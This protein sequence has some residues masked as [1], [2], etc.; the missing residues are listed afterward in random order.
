[1]VSDTERPLKQEH[2]ELPKLTMK[3]RRLIK[4]SILH[5]VLVSLSA[6]FM[7]PFFWMLTTALKTPAELLRGT[8]VLLP[9]TPQ[10][11]NF[12][13]AVTQV[14]FILY[15]SNSLLLVSLSIAGTLFSTTLSAYAFAKLSWPGRDTF[16]IVM[17]ATMMIPI[18]VILIPSYI[19]Y[20]QI[21][22]LGTRLPLIV[23]FF[24]GGG[25][26]FYIFLLR[27][28]FKGIPREL[29]ES[30]I[31]DGAGHFRIFWNIMLPLTKPALI[32]ITL[33][34]FM[35]VWNDYFGP[36]IYLS[37]PDHWTLALGLRA[38]QN[39]YSGRFDLMM[40][41]AI[42][43]MLPTLVIFFLAQRQFIEGITFT[44]IKG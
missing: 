21:G 15:L 35:F 19:L 38:F 1:M 12:R 34:T 13:I 31:M 14:P 37:N 11:Q 33:F 5:L 20:A 26:A 8:E 2:T 17:L 27:Q 44:G 42:L 36:L 30:A 9:A 40:A 29:T 28:F 18:Q 41:A 32:T 25:S 24:F 10:W 43:V 3:Q 6:L 23:P 22:W 7:F 4:N 16:F 39:Q